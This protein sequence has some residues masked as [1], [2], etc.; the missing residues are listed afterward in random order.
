MEAPAYGGSNP[1]KLTEADVLAMRASPATDAELSKLHRVH[2]DTIRAARRGATW[3]HLP[4]ALGPR[5][6]RRRGATGHLS[7]EDIR[8]IRQSPKRALELAAQYRLT[9]QTLSR[10]KLGQVRAE[11]GGPIRKAGARSVGRG[12]PKPAKLTPAEVAAIR[13]GAEPLPELAQRHGISIIIANRIRQGRP[14]RSLPNYG[15][16]KRQPSGTPRVAISDAI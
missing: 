4:G 6:G 5:Q 8:A 12:K 9:P 3:A 10:I 11:A 13:D 16:P 1:A 14:W 7:D 15:P 2:K